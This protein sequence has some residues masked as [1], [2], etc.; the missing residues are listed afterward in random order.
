MTPLQANS[1]NATYLM[2]SFGTVE[3][4]EVQSRLKAGAEPEPVCGNYGEHDGNDG[5]PCFTN[6]IGVAAGG[7]GTPMT[8]LEYSAPDQPNFFPKYFLGMRG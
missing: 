5:L 7:R 1:V 6:N 3:C 8:Q 2:P 4:T